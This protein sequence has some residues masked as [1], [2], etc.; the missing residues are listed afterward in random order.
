MLK[1]CDQEAIAESNTLKLIPGRSFNE[2][3]R[4]RKFISREFF[5]AA[6]LPLVIIEIA[7]LALYFLMNTY[8]LNRSVETMQ[9]DRRSHLM[10]ITEEQA[11]IIEENLNGISDLASILQVL[12][13]RFFQHPEQ[14]P[15]VD[16]DDSQFDFSPTGLYYKLKNDG[17]CSLFYSDLTPIGPREKEKA[18]R[19]E[20]LDPFYKAIYDANAKGHIVA[21]YLNTHD[22]MCRYYPFHE[23]VYERVVSNTD[24]SSYSFYYLADREHNPDGGATW[25]EAYLDPMG[26]GWMMSCLV[27]VYRNDFLEGVAGIDITIKK[28][29]DNL[30]SLKTPWDSHTFLVDAQGTIM[31][32]PPK[33]EHIFGLDELDEYNYKGKVQQDT[34][35]PRT[36]NLL[37]SVLQDIRQPV[38]DLMRKKSGAIT[39]SL[40]QREY[41]LCQSTVLPAGWKLM[42]IAD[43]A[44]ISSPIVQLE[45]Q[46]RL[47]GYLAVGFMCF[48]YLLFF[49]Y[50]LKS[51]G[52]L[53]SRI[54]RP[55]R[56]LSKAIQAV[57]S[58]DYQTSLESS[59]VIELDELSGG[60][61]AMSA[62]LK[63]LHED[64]TNQVIRANAS[65]EEAKQAQEALA[66]HQLLLEGTVERRTQ[67]LTDANRRLEE[68]IA[69]RK[70][71]E[72]A[73]D[74][75]RRQL[76]SVFESISEIIYVSDP[77][78]HEVL[79]IN[80][81]LRKVCHDAV[82]KKCHQ[83]FQGLDKP[84]PFCTNSIIFGE[85][86]GKAHIW[87]HRNRSN[88]M[89]TR[90]IDK[91]IKWPDGRMVRYEMAIDITDQKEAAKERA[92][93]AIR[94][95]RA[96]KMEA[97]GTLAGG[98]A[99]DLNNVLGGIVAYPEL[100][101]LKVREND[102]L[103]NLIES[104]RDAGLRAAAIVQD[105]L[106]LARRGVAVMEAVNLNTVIEKFLNSPEFK[107]ISNNHAGVAVELDLCDQLLNCLGSPVHLSKMIMNLVANACEA[108]T[109]GG[110]LFIST[111]N[112][113]VDRPIKGYEEVLK[114]QYVRVRVCDT[115][116]GIEP[117]DLERIFEPF[118][119][120]KK[121]GR[122]G[123]GLGMAVVWGTVKDHRGYIEIDSMVGKGTTIDIYF[124]ITHKEAAEPQG[125]TNFAGLRGNGETILIVDDEAV[126]RDLALGMLK[127]MGYHPHAVS[128]GEEA[129]VYLE[130]HPVDVMLLDM[131]MEPNIDGLE[132]YKRAIKIHSGQKAIIASGYAETAAVGEAQRCGAGE[133]LMKPYTIQQLGDALKRTLD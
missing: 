40:N 71:V 16:G 126:Q 49:F 45:K 118:Y 15:G 58:G 82:G 127:Q 62:D 54:S 123:T 112:L 121:M 90:C 2:K 128:S 104:T 114:G 11:R 98:V 75:E 111:D 27:P 48:F 55:V 61:H 129:L 115:G 9:G 21:V 34:H 42:V 38:S 14:F 44:S 131:I 119:T 68:D 18:R 86:T 95:Q 6:L 59:P 66:E 64:L 28:F 8:I 92:Q 85:N 88:G 108:M 35:K 1:N 74:F 51:T 52:R 97:L 50:L 122:S 69:K 3:I 110:S 25:T 125:Q 22:S 76:L 87:E 106:S 39:F 96:E 72:K 12:T 83:V 26:K 32:M 77:D 84:C 99:H 46:A 19:S 41:V 23:N 4:L 132:T 113:T 7:L 10:E 20:A 116:L 43:Q 24:I 117:K 29:I 100:M 91:A 101:L 63:T 70:Q 13:A 133:Y 105:L 57:A 37:E 81:A 93:L 107:Q 80:E 53:S 47:I 120:K 102:A 30:L 109:E 33:V 103:R 5:K 36:F 94:L 73:L 78:T 130:H 65:K 56:K 124:P 79:Y 67:A 31:A 89:W 60:F 17:G